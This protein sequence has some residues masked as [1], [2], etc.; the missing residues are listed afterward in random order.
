MKAAAPFRE[1]AMKTRH[2]V[3]VAFLLCVTACASSPSTPTRPQDWRRYSLRLQ[4]GMTEEQAIAAIGYSPD[5]V[6]L[7]VCG[8]PS[9]SQCR[10]LSY[11]STGQGLDWHPLTVW[12]SS[13]NGK[14]TIIAWRAL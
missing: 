5:S 10:I 13:R 8:A 6:N 1:R 7:N 12:E 14:W 9:N 4:D 2:I 3:L 11:D